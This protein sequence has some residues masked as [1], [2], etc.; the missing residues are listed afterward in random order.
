[1]RER[2]F[3][4]P[5]LKGEDHAQIDCGIVGIVLGGEAGTGT[6]VCA[7]A[8]PESNRHCKSTEIG[9]ITGTNLV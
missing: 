5:L 9:P 6:V 1:M 3:E 8:D 4:V 2:N 7:C